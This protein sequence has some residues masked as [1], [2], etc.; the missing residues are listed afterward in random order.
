M[1]WMRR[2]LRLFLSL[3]LSVPPGAFADEGMWTFDNPPRDLIARRY[4]FSPDQAWLE[5]A[6]LASLRF[7]DGGSGSFVSPEGLVLTN[8]HVAMGQLQKMSTPRKDY[9]RDGFFARARAEEIPCPDLEINQLVSFDD[10][11][12]RVHS[13]I[14]PGVDEKR[15][16]EQRKAETAR[17]EKECA[18]ATGLR[19][20]VVEFYQGG[21]YWL[22]RYKKRTDVRLVMAPEID[23]AFFGGDYDN[24]TYPRF[25]LDFAFFRVYEDGEPVRPERR[26]AWR[27]G[28]AK[29]GEL[30]FVFGHPGSTKRL[31]TVAQLAFER[32]HGAPAMLSSFLRERAALREYAGKGGE[33]ARRAKSS[34]FGVE[35]AIKALAG[36][37]EGLSDPETFEKKKEEERL[38]RERAAAD[39][40]PAGK[41]AGAW[42]RIAGA[43]AEVASAF[44]RLRHYM[45]SSRRGHALTGIAET[46][47][48]Y[49]VEVEKPNEDRYEEFRDSALES[50]RFRLF[51]PAPVYKDLDEALLASRLREYLDDLGR[52]D[53]FVADLL[54]STSP[55]K[56]A[57]AALAATR[58]EDV[59]FRRSLVEG[60]P[61]AVERTDDSLIA[62]ARRVD[63]HY[64]RLRD[65]YEDEIQSV[66]T[67]AGRRIAK[68]RFALYGKN[69]YPDATFTLRLSYGKPASYELGTTRVPYKTVFGGLYARADSFDNEP[70]FR[71]SPRVAA[72]R[73]EVDLSVPLDF[74]T[75]HD[76]IGGNSGSPV[77]NKDLEVVG[78][79]F[80]SN[81]HG[82]VTKYAYTEARARAVAVHS[83]AILEALRGVYG[84]EYL[85]RELTGEE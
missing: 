29:E 53:P 67:R 56:A 15:A 34:L 57:E 82:L 36:M 84:M 85:A 48:R 63:P 12:R 77:V 62:F 5:H 72:A 20:D 64:R 28:G 4:G 32:D 74:V 43:Q 1:A 21:E 68:A 59:E 18:D 7:N 38:L 58:L 9:V 60:G 40:L 75:D 73:G 45:G 79:I 2:P 65:W 37:R 76:I 33:Q 8:H 26:F 27:P 10:V 61:A 44:P 23:A 46:I 80:D 14:E 71:L 22:Y 50:L 51:S 19:C 69:T 25:A 78:L 52:D 39:P 42:D 47:V 41:A 55:A 16:N 3:I 66:V 13:A 83:S 49:V 31:R 24:F 54:G 6:R 70:P 11:T 30:T 35:N 17:I 81:I